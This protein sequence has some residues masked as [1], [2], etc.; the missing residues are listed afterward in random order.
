MAMT[1]G[2]CTSAAEETSTTALAEETSTTALAE[3]CAHVIDATVELS[4]SGFRVTATVR[5]GDTGWDRYAD[6]WEVRDANGAVLG[7]RV[8]AHPHVDEQPFTRSLDGVAIPQG[9]AV[10]EVAARD[11]VHGFCGDTVHVEVPER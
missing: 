10:V 1:L 2:A 6:A 8:L 9:V 11:S 5:S 4:A 7:T 3:E